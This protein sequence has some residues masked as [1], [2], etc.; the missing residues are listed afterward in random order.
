MNILPSEKIKALSPVNV[1]ND[2]L[3]IEAILYYLDNQAMKEHK[4]HTK[5]GWACEECREL[6]KRGI[7]LRD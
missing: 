2:P 3:F 1:T 6:E 5:N 7:N 4:S